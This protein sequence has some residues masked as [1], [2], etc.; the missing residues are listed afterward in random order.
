[1]SKTRAQ[2][3]RKHGAAAAG[4]PAASAP[5]ASTAP[6]SNGNML[7]IAAA[8]TAV[9]LFGYY[10]LLALGQMSQLADGLTMPDMMFGGYGTAHIADLRAAMDEDALGQLSYLHK[11]AGT[12]FPLIFGIAWLLL[13]QLNVDRRWLRWLL[14]LPPLVFAAVDLWEN[15][16]ID[17]LL[18][19]SAPD[20]GQVALASALTVARWVLL[21]LSCVGGLL[22]VLLPATVR[23]KVPVR[24][25]G[26]AGLTAESR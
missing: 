1:M 18:A 14:W 7:L 25:V 10:H 24:P 16:A 20:D 23:G 6:R 12:L 8:A 3:A 17:A 13:I 26:P 9:L 22:A 2:I 4:I 21:G 11:T 5:A 15:V 19:G